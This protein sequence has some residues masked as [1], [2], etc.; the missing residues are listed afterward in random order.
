MKDKHYIA[1]GKIM[2]AGFKFSDTVK[3]A[4]SELK[5]EDFACG[6]VV[7]GC[8]EYAIPLDDL[9]K[10][11][12]L[13]KDDKMKNYIKI[14]GKKIA[15][16]DE[17]AN[18][19]REKFWRYLDLYDRDISTMIGIRCNREHKGEAYALNQVYN[20]ELV[21]DSNEVLCLIPTRK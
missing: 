5:K 21:T 13:I 6:G 18:E 14:D 11:E 9:R 17:A 3:D 16:S 15:I 10:L 12:K 1:V 7:S 8:D 2:E 20:W 19:F 4:V